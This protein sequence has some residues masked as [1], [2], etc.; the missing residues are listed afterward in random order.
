[1]MLIQIDREVD[2]TH[3]DLED[4]LGIDFNVFLLGILIHPQSSD[5][6]TTIFR[7]V[8]Q[9]GRLSRLFL[10]VLINFI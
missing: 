4:L 1:M 10:I 6:I 9:P 3:G 2:S 7:L 5:S 8:R